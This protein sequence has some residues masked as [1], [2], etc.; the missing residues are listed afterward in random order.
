LLPV[1]SF[2]H[3]VWIDPASAAR[4]SIGPASLGEYGR[5][6]G[7]NRV[8]QSPGGSITDGLEMIEILLCQGEL[9]IH[10]R[11]KNLISA[12]QRYE[13]ARIGGKWLSVSASP[14][15]PAEDMMDALR[16]AVR[17]TFPEGRRPQPNFHWINPKRVF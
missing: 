2:L 15:S 9:L 5:T 8:T 13:W 7:A 6:F 12:F 17:A 4:T 3:Q 1:G 14:Q 10:P 11:A 16:Y